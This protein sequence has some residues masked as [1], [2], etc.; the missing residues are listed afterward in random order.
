MEDI[1]A[2]GCRCSMESQQYVH[3]DVPDST[4]IETSFAQGVMVLNLPIM[5]VVEYAA[6]GQPL[7]QKFYNSQIFGMPKDHRKAKPYHDHE[8]GQHIRKITV[9]HKESDKVD[10]GGLD[11]MTL[12][13]IR[14]LEKKAKAGKYVN[15]VK[16]KKRRKEHEGLN[17]LEPD[18]FADM[19]K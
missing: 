8:T 17:Q 4:K 15:K 19:W 1:C 9:P 2:M 6:A 10:R 18:E 7:I 11:N 3:I 13:E 5:P 12:I 16:A 14:A